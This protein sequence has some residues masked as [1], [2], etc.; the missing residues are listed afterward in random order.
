MA[1]GGED[2]LVEADTCMLD[3]QIAVNFASKE[4]LMSGNG[5]GEIASANMSV[6]ESSG[7]ISKPVL[8]L[9]TKGTLPSE[10]WSRLDFKMNTLLDPGMIIDDSVKLKKIKSLITHVW[11]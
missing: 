5:T 2:P 1:E 9:L 7:Y 6:R 10:S 11:Y 8:N 4:Q 3:E